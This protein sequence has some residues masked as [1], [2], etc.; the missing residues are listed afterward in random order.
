MRILRGN[1]RTVKKLKELN[2]DALEEDEYD[3]LDEDYGRSLTGCLEN[4]EEFINATYKFV[5][6]PSITNIESIFQVKNTNKILDWNNIELILCPLKG[7]YNCPICNE[8][9]MIT[10]K[11]AKCGHIICYPCFLQYSYYSNICINFSEF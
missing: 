2:P 11:I 4:S 6:K 9:E 1:S 7:K 5:I 8:E 3:L 10:P